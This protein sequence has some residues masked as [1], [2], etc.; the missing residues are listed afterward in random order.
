MTERLEHAV[1]MHA[2]MGRQVIRRRRQPQNR[3][4][5][6]R[7][8]TQARLQY[9]RDLMQ[10]V[11]AV[12][13]LVVRDVLPKLPSILDAHAVMRPERRDATEDDI[14]AA[15][16][17][18]QSEAAAVVPDSAIEMAAQKN[19][20][21]VTQWNGAQ[22]EKEVRKVAKINLFDNSAGLAQHLELFVA[23]NVDLVK[24]LVF[25]QLDDLK[26]IVMRGA[27]A[28]LHHTAIADQIR[29]R[30]GVTQRRAALIATDQVGKLNGELNQLRQQTLG[31][32]RYRWSTSRDERVRPGHAR[33]DG[34]IQRWDSPPVVD[35][36]T[37]ERGHP[38]QP[39]RCRCQA[40]PIVD[41]VLV[42]AGLMAPDDVE[43][44]Q[45]APRSAPELPRVPP[46]LPVPPP[47]NAPRRR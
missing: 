36:R 22:L 40:I 41:D 6:A 31:I 16:D 25:D 24:S 1:R 4:P 37:G 45:P 13:A 30:F 17:D 39:V 26:G 27:R 32:R 21:R 19:A 43:L 28:G 12:Q 42:E 18:V 38:G 10:M 7:Y 5:P 47:A 2:A 46:T 8:P 35:E 15:F 23:D 9:Y 11:Q 20:L 29:E 14:G 34:T 33:L 44:Q 3:L